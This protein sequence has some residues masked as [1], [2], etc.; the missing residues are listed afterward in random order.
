MV[1]SS[2]TGA[3]FTDRR[4]ASIY[5]SLNPW[6]DDTEFYLSLPGEPPQR[7]LDLGCGT[8]MLAGAYARGG[9][10]VTGVDIAAPML[11]VARRRDRQGEVEW[12]L[13]DLRSYRSESRFDLVVMTGHVFQFFTNDADLQA[14]LSTVRTSLSRDGRFVFESRNPAAEAWLEW[15]PQ[16]SRRVVEDPGAGPVE[17]LD[18]VLEVN[19][20]L[21]EI[22]TRYRFLRRAETL[23]SR[24]LLRFLGPAAVENQLTEAGLAV[25]EVLGDWSRG[26]FHEACA[27]MIF[28]VRNA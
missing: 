28:V 13:S 15:N 4:L 14:A 8:G 5:D 20:D 11:E 26:R 23:T 9:H 2:A 22:E 12:I 19:G 3:E 21:V 1:A 7:I 6:A 24:V 27:E 17:V 16:R 25:E 10:T 18:D